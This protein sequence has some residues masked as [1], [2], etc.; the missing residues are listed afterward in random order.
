MST[1]PTPTPDARPATESRATETP[2]T[3][4]Q[5]TETSPTESRPTETPPTAIAARGRED[6]WTVDDAV[7]AADSPAARTQLLFDPRSIARLRNLVDAEN[8]YG[9]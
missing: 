8:A 1:E 5:S 9:R 2:R 6:P 7:S 3:E 4:S